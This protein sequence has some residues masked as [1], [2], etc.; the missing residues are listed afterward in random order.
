MNKVISEDALRRALSA[1]PEVEG[2]AWLDRHLDES[3]APLLDAPWI[4]DI[5][6]AVKPL[7]GKQDGAVISS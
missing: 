5:D 4:L 7:Y 1:T 6:T 3:V 2:I